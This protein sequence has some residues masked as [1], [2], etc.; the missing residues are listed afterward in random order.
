YRI[1]RREGQTGSFVEIATVGAGVASY[2]DDDA[3]LIPETE[4][5]YRVVAFNGDGDS[6]YTNTA[7]ATTPAAPAGACANTGG[8]DDLA[9]L[10]NI[11]KV[12]AD[13]N[14]VWLAN[15]QPGCEI[16]PWFFGLDS[17]VDSDHPD[18]NVVEVRNFVAAEPQATGEDGN[19]HGTH[20]AGTAAAKDGNGGVVGVAP[21]AAIYGFRVCKDDGSCTYDD[22]IAAVDEVT[23]RKL[24][25]P[26]QPIVANLSLGGP[27]SD[28]MDTALRRSVNGGIVYAIA[29]G[30]GVFGA[31][32][33]PDDAQNVSPARTGDDDINAADGSN[34]DTRRINGALTTTSSDANDQSVGCNYGNPVTIAAPGVSIKSS[35]LNGGYNTISGTSMAT[36][37]TAGAAILYMQNNPAATP[38]EI[39]QAI[40]DRLDP[41]SGSPTPNADGRLNVEDL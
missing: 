40:R 20:T 37:H 33:F 6:A 9:D 30:N 10:W 2:I 8:H 31:C 11:T 4:Y 28:A 27:T 38:T 32:T 34:G 7:C 41:W 13:H 1:E 15:Q 22:I 36:P 16:T 23:A 14:A 18:L 29:A 24:A 21:G 35:W 3:A 26:S 5:C 25:N 17:G 19:G 39:E 12:R